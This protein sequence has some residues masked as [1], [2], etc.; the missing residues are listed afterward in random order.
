VR[1]SLA[2]LGVLLALA[3]GA[4]AA[5]AAPGFLLNL[6]DGTPFDSRES[7]GKQILVLRFQASYCKPC[8][9]ESAA[10]NRVADR[11]KDQGVKVLA[12]HVQDTVRDIR[13]FAR[14]Q[15]VSYAIGLDPRLGVGNKFGFRGTPY[16]VV[17]DRRGEIV[18]S[19]HGVSAVSRLPRTLDELLAKK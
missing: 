10:L 13:A 1:R 15:K 17:I 16:T 6:L 8:V 9:R 18:A 3:V 19:L 2:V 12:I 5:P 4:E 11:Y 14:A 7:I